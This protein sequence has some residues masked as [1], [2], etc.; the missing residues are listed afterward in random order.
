MW[1]KWGEAQISFAPQES[2]MG[3]ICG[4]PIKWCSITHINI[5]LAHQ[6]LNQVYTNIGSTDETNTQKGNAN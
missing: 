1:V 3:Q 4:E 2:N 5:S 6:H